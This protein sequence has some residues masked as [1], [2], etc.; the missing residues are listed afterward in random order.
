M[1]AAKNTLNEVAIVAP[2]HID[3]YWDQVKEL[4]RPAV[5]L[6]DG[7]ELE[8]VHNYLRMGEQM[9]WIYRGEGRIYAA[10]VVEVLK[11]PRKNTVMVLFVGGEKFEEW[12]HFFGQL[13]AYAKMVGA[14]DIE[15]IGRPGWTRAL[16][17]DD[18]QAF[19]RFKVQGE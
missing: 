12:K 8:D 11:Y 6:N 1:E 15:G 17:A 3:I 18:V 2:S 5:D 13:K 4:L 16:G 10:M 7:Y 9:L 19:F 14:A